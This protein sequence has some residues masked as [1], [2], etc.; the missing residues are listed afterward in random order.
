MTAVS[1]IRSNSLVHGG[2]RGG[3]HAV[4]LALAHVYIVLAGPHQLLPLSVLLLDRNM[5]LHLQDTLCDSDIYLHKMNLRREG[6]T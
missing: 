4:A 5:T 3:G 6:L 1:D 2:G